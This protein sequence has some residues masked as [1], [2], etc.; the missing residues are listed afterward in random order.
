MHDAKAYSN[1]SIAFKPRQ[2]NHLSTSSYYIFME[3][4]M[5]KIVLAYFML[6]L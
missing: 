2:H 4:G 3:G 5:F 1:F 6:N